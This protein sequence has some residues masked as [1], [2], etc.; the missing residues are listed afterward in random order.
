MLTAFEYKI[1]HSANSSTFESIVLCGILSILRLR[2]CGP[3]RLISVKHCYILY[4]F[5]VKGNVVHTFRQSASRKAMKLK[6]VND[7]HVIV[8]LKTYLQPKTIKIIYKIFTKFKN[9]STLKIFLIP[10][11]TLESDLCS[12]IRSVTNKLNITFW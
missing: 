3:S 1:I 4:I 8:Y 6:S 2:A 9:L 12:S 10:T 5:R 11:D 7:I